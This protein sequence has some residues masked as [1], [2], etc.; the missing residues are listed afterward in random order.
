MNI[1][2]FR[3]GQ[4]TGK[5]L[6]VEMFCICMRAGVTPPSGQLNI[7]PSSTGLLFKILRL[8][9]VLGWTILES[10]SGHHLRDFTLPHSTH[11]YA[12]TDI[13]QPQ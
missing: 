9:Y 3:L 5:R 2:P 1:N 8:L 12:F 11:G 4:Q 7:I 10:A 13:F 6:V